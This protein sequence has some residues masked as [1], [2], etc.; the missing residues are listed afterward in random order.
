VDE[1]ESILDLLIRHELVVM[2]LYEACAT[3]FPEQRTFWSRLAQEEAGHAEAL[4]ALHEASAREIES[5]L[6]RFAPQALRTSIEFVE[7]KT[8]KLKDGGI[9]TIGALALAQELESAL[10][11]DHF[12]KLLPLADPV[13]R[14]VLGS[15]ASQTKEHQQ[16]ISDALA[17]ARARR[18]RG[19]LPHG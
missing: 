4:R 13:L 16:I 12:S 14:P 2:R 19:D 3:A 15:L 7:D 9:D 5:A 17:E 10:L 1:R 8:A 18:R 6:A 11:E